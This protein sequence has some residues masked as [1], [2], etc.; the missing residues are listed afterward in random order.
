MNTM[1]RSLLAAAVLAYN[2]ASVAQDKPGGY[3]VRPIRLV[4][5]GSPGAGGDM[6]ARAVA[7]MLTDAWG[8]NAIVDS[9]PGGSGVIAVEL[10]ARSAPDGYTLLSLG[11]NFMLLG[12]LKRVPF[13]V[14]KAFDP[15]VPTS[16]Q[17]YVLL[18]NLNM[19][20]KSIK[21]LV[22]YSATQ[23]VTYSGS[24]GVGATVHLGMERFA[25][26]SGAKLLFIPYKGT[27]PG[28]IAAMAGEIQMVAA[29]S[30]AATAAIKTGK[31]RAL[32]ALGLTRIP[33]MPD[34]PTVAEQGFPGFKIT[35]RYGLHAPAGTPRAIVAALNRVVSDG[36]HS[37][38]MRQKLEIEGAQPAERMTPEQLKATIA[39]EYAEVE[40]QVKRLNIKIE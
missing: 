10:A 7:Q 14:L 3:P 31:V 2:S 37:P 30:M 40:Q 19:P 22:A 27:A 26:L 1:T 4:I 39:R 24:S 9:R 6:M 36:M 33:S 28:V 32:A 18:A 13:D 5:S 23:R 38:Q 15:V 11:D 8:Q 16:A 25:Q 29:S 21:E 35:N 17:P 12:A 20:V 34:L